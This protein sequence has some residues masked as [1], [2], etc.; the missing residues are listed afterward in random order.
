ML[1]NLSNEI[2]T[3]LNV[4]DLLEASINETSTGINQ[5]IDSKMASLKEDFKEEIS[6]IM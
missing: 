4:E 5:V 1:G 3:Q 6:K 2:T